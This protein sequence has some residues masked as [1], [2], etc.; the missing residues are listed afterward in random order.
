M[1]HLAR[2]PRRQGSVE[3]TWLAAHRRYVREAYEVERKGAWD[4]VFYGD[5]IVEEWRCETLGLSGALLPTCGWV[6]AGCWRPGCPPPS[7]CACQ[8]PR[9]CLTRSSHGPPGRLGR[10]DRCRDTHLACTEL[11]ETLL[12]RCHGGVQCRGTF[13]GAPW[14]PF[15]GVRK[16]WDEYFGHKPYRA[17]SMGIASEFPWSLKAFLHLDSRSAQV[18]LYKKGSWEPL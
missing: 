6:P 13:M 8:L 18:C 4:V 11:A 7:A 14:G 3:E 10:A 5:S 12:T 17:H 2:R 9:H 16:V 1:R 15:H